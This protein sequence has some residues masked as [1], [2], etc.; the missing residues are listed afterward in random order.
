MKTD[1]LEGV[2]ILIPDKVDAVK[3]RFHGNYHLGQVLLTEND[4]VIIDFEGD[5]ARPFDARRIKHSPLRDVAGMMRSFSC[6][7]AVALANCTS[8]RPADRDRLL[9]YIHEWE[10]ASREVF[11][12][13][14]RD[15]VSDCLV[16]PRADKNAKQLIELFMLEK[17]LYEL[18]YELDHRMEWVGIPLTGLLALSH[19]AKPVSGEGM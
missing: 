19:A 12:S 15:G 18:R 5:P 6:A 3:T 9:P 11:L 13:G 10:I 4:F 2:N 7:G 8:V 1:L 14:Y 17:A 16:W